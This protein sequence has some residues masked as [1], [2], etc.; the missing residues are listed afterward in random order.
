MGLVRVE[1]PNHG[2]CTNNIPINGFKECVGHCKSGTNYAPGI[3][4]MLK[5]SR[6]SFRNSRLRYY[7]SPSTGDE[8]E[9]SEKWEFIDDLPT[10]SYRQI[11]ISYRS[12]FNADFEVPYWIRLKLEK[13]RKP[14]HSRHF[15]PSC[16]SLPELS[17][18]ESKCTCCQVESEETLRM[19]LNCQ[20]GTVITHKLRV[21]SSC[22]CLAC[23]GLEASSAQQTSGIN[24]GSQYSPLSE[25]VRQVS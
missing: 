3:V 21:P 10:A 4:R 17:G 20:D 1:D 12:T 15:R 9:I 14:R 11:S 6:V 25:Y 5:K 24:P 2:L 7:E 22:N 18:Q 8:V 16:F 23:S 13:N 19:A